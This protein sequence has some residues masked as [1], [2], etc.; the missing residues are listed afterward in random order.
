VKIT[1]WNKSIRQ[2]ISKSAFLPFSSKEKVC[3][4][5]IKVVCYTV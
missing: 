5:E 2:C 3:F 1:T 4:E